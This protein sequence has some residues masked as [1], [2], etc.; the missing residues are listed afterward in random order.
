MATHTRKLANPTRCSQVNFGE[1]TLQIR[2]AAVDGD[3][4]PPIVG[5]RAD[6]KVRAEAQQQ[7]SKGSA[8]LPLA[9][10]L[11]FTAR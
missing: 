2:Y 9:D 4:G 10:Y 8:V 3:G 6:D 5:S 1:Y 7:A 11:L